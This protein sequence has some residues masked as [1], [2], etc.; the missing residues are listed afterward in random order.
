MTMEISELVE[1]AHR[2]FGAGGVGQDAATQWRD[3]TDM[4]WFMMTVPEEDGG[5]GLGWDAVAVIQR[6][7]GRVLASGAGMAQMLVVEALSRAPASAGRDDFLARVMGGE[8]VTASLQMTGM[9]DG[10]SAFPDADQAGLMLLV[11]RDKISLHAVGSATYRQTWDATRRLF[12]V[13]AGAEQLVLASGA[14]AAALA[15]HLSSFISLALA[16]DSLGGAQ[17]VLDLTVEY[18]QTR[19]QFDRPLAAFQALKHRLSDMKTALVAAEA[20][21]GAEARKGEIP[22]TLRFG[23]VK[24][25]ACQAYQQISEEAI[26]LHGGIGLTEEHPV[27]LYFKRA[28]LNASLGGSADH[29]TQTI[30]AAALQSAA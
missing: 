10:L 25:Y 27:H 9:G 28:F 4:G 26:Q 6:E 15:D 16:A 3:L 2:A 24:A 22:D 20:L 1:S 13:T 14:E 17:A 29:W 5:L 23:G 21:M 30:G 19:R 7:L 8:A 11:R 18:V 12:D